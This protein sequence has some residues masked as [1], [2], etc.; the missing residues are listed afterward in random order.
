MIDLE[1]LKKKINK[2]WSPVDVADV[3]NH[4]VSMAL[5]DGEYRWHKHDD[6]EELFYVLSGNI[7]I[8]MKTGNMALKQGQMY[9]VPKGVEHCPK[10][11][12]PSYVLMVEPKHN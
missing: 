9:V 1:E 6:F 8:Q 7:V 11:L 12:E 10:A 5:F 2:P 4:F 3:N